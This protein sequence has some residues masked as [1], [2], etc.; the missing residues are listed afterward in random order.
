[1][2][3]IIYSVIDSEYQSS[4]RLLTKLLPLIGV[5]E[6]SEEDSDKVLND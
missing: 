2:L 6:A 1:M 4:V 3:F 5:F